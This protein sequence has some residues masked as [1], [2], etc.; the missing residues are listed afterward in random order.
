LTK[1]DKSYILLYNKDKYKG[2]KRNR[3]RRSRRK[4]KQKIVVAMMVAFSL[5]TGTFVL[6]ESKR[7]SP[8]VTIEQFKKECLEG[9]KELLTLD[10][11]EKVSLYNVCKQD[12][13]AITND[14]R[15]RE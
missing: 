3:K 4:M 7:Q 13:F 12:C 9:C 11:D 10:T 6:S 15:N 5:A 8:Q 2:P 1:P 14:L